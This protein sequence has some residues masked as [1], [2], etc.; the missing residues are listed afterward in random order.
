MFSTPALAPTPV[1]VLSEISGLLDALV[2]ATPPADAEFVQC[3]LT[4][5]DDDELKKYKVIVCDPPTF[6]SSGA[7]DRCAGGGGRT[8][9][10]QP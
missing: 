5:V 6:A 7:A 9:N 8:L 4:E 10:L 1:L 3:A 2:A